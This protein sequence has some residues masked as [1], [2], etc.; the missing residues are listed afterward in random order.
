MAGHFEF[1]YNLDG[2]NEPP[3]VQEAPVATTQTLVVGDLVVLS[4]S[5]I[6]KASASV[7]LPFGVMAENS[8]LATA[9]T[10]VKFYVLHPLQVWRAVADAAATSY[11]LAA[12]VHDINS[13]Q[14]VDVGDASA[15]SIFIWKTGDSTTDAYISFSVAAYY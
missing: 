4:S 10:M 9:G 15:G 6:A 2:S 7:A 11:I 13:D 14:T 8:T 12:K 3:A 5:Q 1:A